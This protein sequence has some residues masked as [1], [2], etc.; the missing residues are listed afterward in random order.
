M[1]GS[2]RRRGRGR[3]VETG[4]YDFSL[5]VCKCIYFV[6]EGIFCIGAYTLYT[7]KYFLLKHWKT[8]DTSHYY[9]T[10]PYP[11]NLE[12]T[13]SLNCISKICTKSVNLLNNKPSGNLVNLI[14]NPIAQRCQ[15]IYNF[16]ITKTNKNILKYSRGRSGRYTLAW[17]YVPNNKRLSIFFHWLKKDI[18]LQK[19][20][21]YS[22]RVL[23]TIESFFLHPQNSFVLKL[24]NFIHKFIYN[25][26]KNK[27]LSP[28]K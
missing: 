20:L 7:S 15:P 6:I 12:T 8:R 5:S 26:Y 21:K 14:L 10:K 1:Q 13:K 24:K 11:Q 17:E 18:K 28:I 22:S 27:L 4:K 9:G 19:H 23:K 3:R 2:D 25:K 16:Y